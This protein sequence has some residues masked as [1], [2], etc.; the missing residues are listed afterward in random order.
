[1]CVYFRIRNIN[2]RLVVFCV[3]ASTGRRGAESECRAGQNMDGH[4]LTAAASEGSSS[5]ASA[6]AATSG[7][8]AAASEG[9]S[10]AASAEAATS[11]ASA[12]PAAKQRQGYDFKRKKIEPSL[13]WRVE[14][15][16]SF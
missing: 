2:S 1:M 6:E 3:F 9:S 4:R 10:S 16:E 5:A 12:A 13:L 7:A 14:T 11:G 15:F 8:S